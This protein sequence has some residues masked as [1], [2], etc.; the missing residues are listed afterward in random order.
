MFLGEVAV[1]RQPLAK[2]IA[3]VDPT[4]HCDLCPA[5][6]VGL[7]NGNLEVFLHTEE[8]QLEWYM[9]GNDVKKRLRRT[10]NE[11]RDGVETKL[12]IEQFKIDIAKALI[13]EVHTGCLFKGTKGVEDE[14][15]DD[16]EE[17]Q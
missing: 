2:L 10:I 7:S 11:L 8:D 3:Q 14:G 9:S 6:H 4:L 13:R 15:F 17:I 16:S 12:Q 1:K 5:F